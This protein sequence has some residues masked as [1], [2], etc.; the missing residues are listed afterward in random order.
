RTTGPHSDIKRSTDYAKKMVTEYGMSDRLGPRTFGDRQEMVFL[1]REISEQ[2]DYSERFALEIDREVDALIGGAYGVAKD[3]LAKNKAKLVELAE[4]LLERETLDGD[5][6]DA[7]FAKKKSRAKPP[8]PPE[9]KPT[10]VVVTAETP[11]ASVR[12]P[13]ARKVPAVRPVLP[14]PIPGSE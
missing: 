1:G 9:A 4:L 11:A 6:L 14:E 7:L 2:K 5:D 13:R 8:K 10:P 12:K 3:L